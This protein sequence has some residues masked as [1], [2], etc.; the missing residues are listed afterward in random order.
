MSRIVAIANQKGGVGKT[1]TTLNL[2]HALAEHGHTVLL[3]DFDAQCSLTIALQQDLPKEPPRLADVLLDHLP[4]T[5]LSEVIKPTPFDGVDVLPATPELAEAEIG[6]V[7]AFKGE[8]ALKRALSTLHPRYDFILIDCP[9]NLGLLTTN[10]LVAA[11][12]VVVPIES[13][14]L[15]LRGAQLIYRTIQKVRRQENGR[16]DILGVLVTKHDKRTKHA[17]EML[18]EIRQAFGD[19][20][21]DSVIPLSVTARDAVAQGNSILSY[22]TKSPLAM[23]YRDVSRAIIMK[24]GQAA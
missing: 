14:Y 24:Y 7:T 21:F 16:P 11:D 6:L 8:D 15:A 5:T 20:V 1:M 17:E 12:S 4:N 18:E 23:A 9:P 22:K 19:L 2:G 3:V 10:A 13:D